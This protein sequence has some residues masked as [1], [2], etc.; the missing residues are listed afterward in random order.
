MGHAQKLPHPLTRRPHD[1]LGGCTGSQNKQPNPSIDG[2]S[3]GA[4]P[5][6][7][8]A[9]ELGQGP[10]SDGP[11][12]GPLPKLGTLPMPQPMVVEGPP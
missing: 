6:P 9:L 2:A 1:G 7:T 3:S 12:E 8:N 4:P 11:N 10:L 5:K